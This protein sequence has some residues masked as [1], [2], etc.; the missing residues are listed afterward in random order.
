MS[1]LPSWN[2][3][4]TNKY[5]IEKFEDFIGVPIVQLKCAV[6]G[7]SVEFGELEVESGQGVK[8]VVQ[9]VIEFHLQ[10]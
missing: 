5:I 6:E 4:K 10:I 8:E 3:R 2:M 7:V 9:A 1:V